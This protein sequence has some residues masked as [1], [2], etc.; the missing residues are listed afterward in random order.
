MPVPTRAPT[1]AVPVIPY[2]HHAAAAVSAVRSRSSANVKQAAAI[3]PAP[4]TVP[5]STPA[6]VTNL[7][8]GRRT[9]IF[10]LA[11]LM[12]SW[13]SAIA[14]WSWR[15]EQAR[16]QQSYSSIGLEQYAASSADETAKM[17]HEVLRGGTSYSYSSTST[18]DSKVVGGGG[19]GG[20]DQNAA[21]QDAG[22]QNAHVHVEL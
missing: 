11:A 5:V 15:G 21:P 18:S 9:V 4:A 13:S 19:D 14:L 8:V 20:G 22:A 1:P 6:V 10:V 2:R 12:F 3:A 16:L 7:R 17:V